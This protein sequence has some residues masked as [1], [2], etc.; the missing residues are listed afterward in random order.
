MN[1]RSHSG[2]WKAQFICI[3][4]ACATRSSWH[5]HSLFLFLKKIEKSFKLDQSARD[6]NYWR[7]ISIKLSAGKIW[8]MKFYFGADGSRAAHPP[9]EGGRFAACLGKSAKSQSA[10]QNDR[11]SLEEQ[12]THRPP[13]LCGRRERTQR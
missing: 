2:C 1:D 11:K 6:A 12:R 3:A 8:P 13:R 9:P 5:Q 4:F 7:F 10:A